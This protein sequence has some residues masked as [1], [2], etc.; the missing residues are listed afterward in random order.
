MPDIK[1]MTNNALARLFSAEFVVGVLAGAFTLG[2]IWQG[3]NQSIEAN[4]QAVQTVSQR[5]ETTRAKNMEIEKQQV[6]LMVSDV[7]IKA[8][9]VAQ[10][11]RIIRI[12]KNVDRI[13]NILEARK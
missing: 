5:L 4:T 1:Q 11:E 3:L 13:L 2:I 8:N 9:Q 12:E 6:Q 7:E 10:S